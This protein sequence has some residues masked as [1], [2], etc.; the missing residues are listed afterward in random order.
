MQ[1]AERD[2]SELPL[3]CE[4]FAEFD[5]DAA[6]KHLRPVARQP[7]EVVRDKLAAIGDWTAENVHHAIQATADELEVGMGKVG[8]PLRVAVTGAGQVSCA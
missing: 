5:A 2:C 8:M 7:L 6:K 3:P 1:S 4:E